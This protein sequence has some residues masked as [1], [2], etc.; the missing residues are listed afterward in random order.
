MKRTLILAVVLVVFAA[1]VLL[2]AQAIISEGEIR[3]VS[4][5]YTP[6]SSATIRV[7]TNIVEV[8]VVVRDE[9]G[10]PVRGLTKDDFHVF[11]SG[12]PQIIS[13]FNVEEE[14]GASLPVATPVT[15]GAAAPPLP[16]G[17]PPRYI[18][19]YFDDNNMQTPD[20]VMARNAAK[21]FVTSRMAEGDKVAVFTSSTTVTQ[22][23]TVEKQKLL[24]AMDKV[25]SHLRKASYGAGACPH[26]EPYQA[27]QILQHR[28]THSEPFDLALEQAIKCNC[29]DARTV[30]PDPQCITQQSNLVEV[31][32]E[33]TLGLADQFAMDT[34]GALGDIIRYVGKMPGHKL[35]VMTSSGYFSM[36]EKVKRQQDRMIDDALRLGIR[37]NSLDSKGLAADWLN[38]DP[39]D[40]PPTVVERIYGSSGASA[41]ALQSYQQE[42]VSDE[43][44][45]TSDSMAALA[46]GTGGTFFHNSND[47]TGGIRQMAMLPEV[48]YN[49][50]FLPAQ[51]KT[52]GAYHP[53]KVKLANNRGYSIEARPGYFAPNKT[54]FA[55]QDRLDRLN[56]TVMARD[57]AHGIRAGVETKSIELATGEP[58]LRVDVRVDIRSLPFRK[59]NGRH[60]ERLIF[61]TALFDA[62]N[63]FLSGVEGVMEMNIKEG[64]LTTLNSSGAS[65]VVTLQ[66]PSGSYRLRQVIQEAVTGRIAAFN[67]PVEIK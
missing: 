43:R 6:Q 62:D 49:L 39:G 38:G 61:I 36:S 15:L 41:P 65:A 46:E 33:Y 19:F 28:N 2:H 20:L 16:S 54:V 1:A 45:I 30:E 64:T 10:K 27:F 17:P 67:T 47:L 60:V 63:K 12:K 31:Q 7:Q 3:V 24:D 51:L 32:A 5:P 26:I 25:N 52:N 4:E 42:L 53:L 8:G 14:S 66:A 56:K 11:D 9:Y 29:L 58:A 44:A 22:T 40:G 48:S 13:H 21:K 59:Q 35:L 37:I 34:L 57:E 55:P 50:E 18:G 23:F